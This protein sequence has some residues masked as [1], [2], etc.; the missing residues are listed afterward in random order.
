ML[1]EKLGV[2]FQ[3]VRKY[4]KGANRVIGARLFEIR[5]VLARLIRQRAAE[6]LASVV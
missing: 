2:T 3:Q 5:E 4:E 6:R 1:G